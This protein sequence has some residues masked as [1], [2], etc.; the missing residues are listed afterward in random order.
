MNHGFVKVAAAIPSLKVADCHYNELQIESIT[1]QAAGKGVEIICF[2]EL[3]MT[4]YTCADLFQQQ[5]LLEE[6]EASVMK[7]LT[8]TRS[9]DI[10]TII[11]IP[12][13][14]NGTLRSCHA[15]RQDSC[16]CTKDLSAKL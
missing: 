11:G 4:G 5:L 6:C 14:Y 1:L 2:P 3:C 12:L 15:T 9:L 13:E 16:H 7:L 8:T 10:I